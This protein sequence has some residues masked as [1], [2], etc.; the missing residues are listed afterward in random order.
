MTRPFNQLRVRL[1]L[2]VLLAVLPA[3]GVTIATG[4]EQRRLARANAETDAMQLAHAAAEYQQ[5][6]IEGARQ[7][8]IAISLMPEIHSGSPA[9]C[10]AYLQHLH[11]HFPLYSTFSVAD[12]KGNLFCSSLDQP[13]KINIG[14]RDYFSQA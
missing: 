6:L 9:E 4:I 3:I 14:D 11:Q 2:L 8:M 1:I 10:N 5:A 7:L 12:L 13:P